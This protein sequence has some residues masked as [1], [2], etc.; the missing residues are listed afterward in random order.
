M[1][2]LKQNIQI[3]TALIVSVLTLGVP[4]ER[5]HAEQAL[6][7]HP[8]AIALEA[9]F[10]LYPLVVMDYTRRQLSNVPAGHP[11]LAAPMNVFAASRGFPTPE[12]HSVP[13]PNFDTLYSPSWLDLTKGP[14]LMNTPNTGDRY[15]VVTMLDMWS[16]VFASVGTRTTGNKAGH[17]L[18]TPPGWNGTRPEGLPEGTIDIPA[19]T[20][21]VWVIGRIQ[22]NGEKDF[23]TVHALQD[24]F[25]LVAYDSKGRT[26][27]VPEFKPD[28]G[29]DMKTPPNLQVEALSASD[30][31]ATAAELLKLHPPH[32]IDWPILQRIRQIGFIAGESYDA[33]AQPKN[34]VAALNAAPADALAKMTWKFPR[35]TSP[36]NQ[37]SIM[38]GGIGTY[39]TAYFQRAVIAKFG[40]G[41]N[42]PQD[43]VYPLAFA[44][45]DGN[46][47]DGKND[48][49][50]HFEKSELP[51]VQAF[52]SLALYDNDGF[53]VSNVLNRYAVSSWMPLVYN[54]DGSLDIYI[55][56]D[57]P[58]ADKET[59]WLPSPKAGFG[60]NMRLYAP[61]TDVT[62]GKWSPPAVKLKQTY[63]IAR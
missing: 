19:P 1:N 62:T 48:Y 9:Y 34:I 3:G 30:F 32:L 25:A 15:K 52:W 23:D 13:R 27:P 46:V 50:L 58:G 17:F 31:F 41:S 21:Y 4:N 26:L 54:E 40:L 33:S 60:L 24:Q 29:V 47:F 53:P 43:S 5:A 14:V 8:E 55:Q 10:Y 57:S 49:V 42:V 37:W 63:E 2:H 18:V 59:N 7:K 12:M 36:V 6:A 11:G 45:A 39:G 28:P 38:T 56:T 51:P 61:L 20:L 22:T 16:E 44:D 35:I